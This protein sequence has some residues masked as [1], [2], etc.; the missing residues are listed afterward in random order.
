MQNK[1]AAVVRL[2]GKV[3]FFRGLPHDLGARRF[4][5][6]GSRGARIGESEAG[7]GEKASE[8]ERE[9]DALKTYN[10]RKVRYPEKTEIGWERGRCTQ[11][12]IERE[13]ERERYLQCLVK[14]LRG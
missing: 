1:V 8:R 9:R 10:V 5:G 3:F 6:G 7:S 11:T 2:P 14:S 12:R 13:R 4:N